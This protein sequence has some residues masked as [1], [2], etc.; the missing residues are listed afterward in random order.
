LML[1]EAGE[2]PVMIDGPDRIVVHM[3]PLAGFRPEVRVDLRDLRNSRG[4]PHL[5]GIN[6]TDLRFNLD[7]F[8]MYCR[9]SS[10]PGARSYSQI[11]HNGA[12][13]LVTGRLR[14]E[15][16][17]ES[18]LPMKGLEA[19]LRQ[20]LPDYLALFARLGVEPPIFLAVSLLG[21]RGSIMGV[22]NVLGPERFTIDRDRVLAPEAMIESFQ[23]PIDSALH[24]ICDAL[25]NA[26][27]LEGSPG[28]EA[29]GAWVG[30]NKY[31]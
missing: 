21:V 18:Y 2:M 14:L 8:L 20:L 24:P 25:W 26:G 4:L 3:V 22:P 29:D 30:Q 27:G 17:G 13:E 5:L 15:R 23:Q 9:A 6:L 12:V 19:E 1:I 10:P 7:G 11:F 31:Y 28:Y 16:D